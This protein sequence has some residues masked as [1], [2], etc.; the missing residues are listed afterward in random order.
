[1]VVDCFTTTAT[2]M[3]ESEAELVRLWSGRHGTRCNLYFPEKPSRL[4][5]TGCGVLSK[6]TITNA[7]RLLPGLGL[8]EH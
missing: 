6:L 1:M 8:L 5:T 3:E 2:D 7:F 4:T